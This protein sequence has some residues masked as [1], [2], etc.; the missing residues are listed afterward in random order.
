MQVLA[1]ADAVEAEELE[2]EELLPHAARSQ[3]LSSPRS[4]SRIRRDRVNVIR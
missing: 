4:G 1:E 2:L 3:A